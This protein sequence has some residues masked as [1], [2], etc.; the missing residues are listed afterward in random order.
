[1]RDTVPA[2]ARDC[3]VIFVLTDYGVNSVDGGT[4]RKGINFEET[5][6]SCL[7]LWYFSLAS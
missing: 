2:E 6:K 7:H 4:G 1:M 5:E 3:K